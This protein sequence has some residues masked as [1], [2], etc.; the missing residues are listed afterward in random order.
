[1][2]NEPRELE[3][4]GF[5]EAEALTEDDLVVLRQDDGEEVQCVLLAIVDHDE[6]SFALL[7]RH[8]MLDADEPGDLLVARYREDEDGVSHFEPM[9]DD[10]VLA[11]LR[12]AVG[13][14]VDL[15]S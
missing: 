15:A 1:M 12:D 3:E 8:D 6:T 4:I 5:D 14:I 2:T 9:L 10:S 11:S 13:H 7:T